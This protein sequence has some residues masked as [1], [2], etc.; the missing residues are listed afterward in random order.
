[1]KT[2]LSKNKIK[3]SQF[4]IALDYIKESRKEIY[5][6]ILLFALFTFIGFVFSSNLSF[7]DRYLSGIIEQTKDLSGIPLFWFILKNN[8]ITSF[9]SLFPGIILA[10]IPLFNT[11]TNGLIIGY[12]IQKVSMITGFLDLWRLLPHG[13]FELPAIFISLGLGIKLGTFLF[14]K[15]PLKTLKEYAYKS[16]LVFILIVIPLLIIAAIIESILITFIK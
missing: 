6:A 2:K 4:K 14:R 10:L 3:D 9:I 5:I 13:I 12:V 8:A 1:M 15:H 11:V 16:L 7:L